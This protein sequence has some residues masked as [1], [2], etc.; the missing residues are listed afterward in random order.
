MDEKNPCFFC[1]VD[2]L[3][4]P[5]EKPFVYA[6]VVDFAHYKGAHWPEYTNCCREHRIA[7]NEAVLKMA[8][9]M[10]SEPPFDKL[11]EPPRLVVSM[12]EENRRR[13]E[14]EKEASRVRHG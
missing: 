9:A 3:V 4:S 6:N 8:A 1:V 11:A 2:K 12:V 7:A 5:E 13:F 10:T 14:A